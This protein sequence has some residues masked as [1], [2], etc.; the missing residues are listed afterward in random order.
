[1]GAGSR[2]RLTRGQ[3]FPMHILHVIKSLSPGG[4]SRS[5][6]AL[7]RHLRQT[8]QF[9]HT[10]ISLLP[11]GAA[12]RELARE[13]GFRVIEAPDW[14]TTRALVAEAD[15]V[16]V[17]WW[18]SPV[19][20]EFLWS[21]LPRC[22]LLIYV[23]V[24][25]DTIPSVLTPELVEYADFCVACCPYTGERN[26]IRDLP[27]AMRERKTAVVLATTDFDR[28]VDLTPRA[29]D[30]FNVG[31][32]GTVDFRK[33]HPGFVRMSAAV[34]LPDVKFVVCGHGHLERVQQEAAR[35]GAADR[36][37]F[38]G[39]V[40]DIRPVLETLDVY[41]YP[42]GERPGSELNV[43]EVMFAGVPPIVFPLGGLRDLVAH[44]RTGLVV[45]SEHEYA[46]AIEYLQ[47][48]PDVRRRLGRN[49]AL[50]ARAHF[51]AERSANA[52][53]LIYEQLLRVP[54]RNHAWPRAPELPSSAPAVGASAWIASLGDAAAP[55]QRSV[56]AADLD[57]VL[58]AEHEIAAL[59]HRAVWG[60]EEYLGRYPQD[61]FLALWLGLTR[62]GEDRHQEADALLEQAVRS[63]MKHWRIAWYRARSRA[64]LDRRQ[65]GLELCGSVLQTAEGLA[66]ARELLGQPGRLPPAGHYS[67]GVG[68]CPIETPAATAPDGR[69]R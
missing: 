28:L 26:A 13:A 23:H 33:M 58:A 63:G 69:C 19:L 24:A 36:F 66:P 54:K 30:S 3:V 32:I 20:Y 59:P 44:E 39:Y 2:G 21:D 68:G 16:H 35:L 25:G 48:E 51:G 5:L 60:L 6:C 14:S 34:L 47:R 29:H 56:S 37:D 67:G 57:T 7:G 22:R 52:L 64:R 46:R 49:A 12:P 8:G 40:A 17:E 4:A 1:M 18:N 31:Y 10:V 38:R 41:G 45:Q 27:A 55:F 11:A 9:R 42:L 15:I 65:Q 50:H 61:P 62:F 43:Q 53:G